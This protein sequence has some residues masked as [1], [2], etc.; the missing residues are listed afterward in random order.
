MVDDRTPEERGLE[1]NE[2]I[3]FLEKV[4]I[5]FQPI[6]NER[7]RL[8]KSRYSSVDCYISPESAIYNDIDVPYDLDVFRRLTE[9]GK[10]S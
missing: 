8:S 2:W 4:L 1:V 3:E 7:F 10:I 5:L 9:N 6:Q